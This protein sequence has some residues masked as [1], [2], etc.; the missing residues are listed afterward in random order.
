MIVNIY[1][2]VI[3]KAITIAQA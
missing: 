2:A 3:A 1:N